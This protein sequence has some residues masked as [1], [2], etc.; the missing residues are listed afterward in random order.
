MNPRLHFSPQPQPRPS[1]ARPPRLV[2]QAACQPFNLHALL[3]REPCVRVLYRQRVGSFTN[4]S[5]LCVTHQWVSDIHGDEWS[6]IQEA[7]AGATQREWSRM[8]ASALIRGNFERVKE[9]HR[10]T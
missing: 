3:E 6:A 9:D 5:S 7:C 4:Y 2:T 1:H 10:G 8:R